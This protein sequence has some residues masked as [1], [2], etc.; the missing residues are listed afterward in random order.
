MK[1]SSF[2]K[3]KQIL[4]ERVKQKVL[5]RCK[6]NMAKMF[7]DRI[8]RGYY[9]SYHDENGKPNTDARYVETSMFPFHEVHEQ[10]LCYKVL[11]VKCFSTVSEKASTNAGHRPAIKE[12][13][14]LK[15][16]FTMRL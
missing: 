13:P 9:I 16:G 7:F 15:T 12:E 1:E 14:S 10:E 3:L 8:A 4:D 11:C 6:D 5:L 2:A